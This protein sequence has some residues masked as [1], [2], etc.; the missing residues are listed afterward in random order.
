MSTASL[1][2]SGLSMALGLY[3]TTQIASLKEAISTISGTVTTVPLND[4]P[5]E[6]PPT[7]ETETVEDIQ[8][9]EESSFVESNSSEIQELQTKLSDLERFSNK[10]STRAITNTNNVTI[11][12]DELGR[13]STFVTEALVAVRE[14]TSTSENSIMTNAASIK[15]N[16]STIESII[17]KIGENIERLDLSQLRADDIVSSLESAISR[18]GAAESNAVQLS[19]NVTDIV[20]NADE[21]GDR[22][23]LVDGIGIETKTSLENLYSSWNSFNSTAFVAD[24]VLNVSNIQS[25]NSILGLGTNTGNA[26]HFASLT[27][28]AWSMYLSNTAGFTPDKVTKAQAYDNITSYGIHMRLGSRS[29]E[30]LIIE[31]S[32]GAG[33]M[34]LSSTG[35]MTMGKGIWSDLFSNTGF[36]NKETFSTTG[37]ALVQNGSGKTQINSETGQDL[38]LCQ[39]GD[40]KVVISNGGLNVNNPSGTNTTHFNLNDTGNNFI[41]SSEATHFSF[42]TASPTVSVTS[43]EIT[44]N[45]KE[46][47]SA[48]VALEGRVTN[49]EKKQFILN[50]D[51]VRIRNENNDRFLR[52]SS[53]NNSAIMDST[54]RDSRSQWTISH[55]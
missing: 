46:L 38:T 21:L 43:G 39:G 40:P 29:N 35:V 31:N 17:S 47:R 32:G 12:G 16:E 42:G 45:G 34:S 13:L 50:G 4:V 54:S 55:A 52:K 20:L 9:L 8:P 41:R 37:F 53:S 10:V 5:V 51:D 2:V 44:A 48:I 25:S 27:N 36:G 30:G 49:L 23:D 14:R 18:I 11:K 26:I 7:A 15:E 24:N 3:N 19:S 22:L 1:G 33:L 28:N 6:A